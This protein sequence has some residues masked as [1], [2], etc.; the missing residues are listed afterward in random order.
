MVEKLPDTCSYCGA[1]IDPRLYFCPACAKPHRPVEELIPAPA[2]PYQDDEV[3]LRVGAKEAWNVFFVY[4][5]AICVSL[6]IAFAIWGLDGMEAVMLVAD[7]VIAVTTVVYT[8]RYWNDLR[9]FLSRLSRL[10]HPWSL[11]G[12][13][14]L[15][16]TLLINYGYHHIV[17][18]WGGVEMEDYNTYFSTKYGALVMICIVPA[19]TEEIA[20]RGIIQHQFEK[21]VSQRVALLVAASVFSAAHLSIVSAPYLALV[22]LLLGCTLHEEKPLCKS[23]KISNKRREKC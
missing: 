12:L 3:K 5:I 17:S 11:L 8:I 20:F 18:E 4:M 10:F 13:A 22:G 2:A 15:A 16:P 14:I 23:L 21:V 19:I 7:V 6:M 9:P 1:K